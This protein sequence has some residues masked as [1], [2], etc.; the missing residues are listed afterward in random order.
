VNPVDQISFEILLANSNNDFVLISSQFEMHKIQT[1]TILGGLSLTISRQ[2]NLPWRG[3]F[4]P[5]TQTTRPFSRVTNQACKR[6]NP[7]FL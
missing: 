2:S 4:L 7:P 1:L 3:P 5:H 6:G